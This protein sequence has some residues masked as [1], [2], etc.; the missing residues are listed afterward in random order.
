MELEFCKFCKR[1]CKFH[2]AQNARRC[3]CCNVIHDEGIDYVPEVMEHTVKLFDNY[4]NMIANWQPSTV[5]IYGHVQERVLEAV[6]ENLDSLSIITLILPESNN[7]ENEQSYKKLLKDME[8]EVM[9]I[10]EYDLIFL[11]KKEM[12]LN[13]FIWIPGNLTT[14]PAPKWLVRKFLNYLRMMGGKLI[15][16]QW[17]RFD[18]PF[19]LKQPITMRLDTEGLKTFITEIGYRQKSYFDECIRALVVS[20]DEGVIEE[21][22]SEITGESIAQHIIS[23]LKSP[24]VVSGRDFLTGIDTILETLRPDIVP[25]IKQ[26]IKK[27][28]QAELGN[29]TSSTNSINDKS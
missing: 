8:I 22:I 26:S 17:N 5:L 6:R 19:F 13:D 23:K 14:A 4:I 20:H 7:L 12:L 25:H 10:K 3:N 28:I 27:F 29:G 16:S 21:K 9:G 15:I 1:V 24:G 2:C 18:I 11:E